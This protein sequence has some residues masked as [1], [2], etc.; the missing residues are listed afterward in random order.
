MANNVIEKMR[1]LET[2]AGRFIISANID[3]AGELRDVLWASYGPGDLLLNVY[4]CSISLCRP[5]VPNGGYRLESVLRGE[6]Y[7]KPRVA[8]WLDS[9]LRAAAGYINQSHHYPL[10]KPLPQWLK[11]LM[12]REE[13]RLGRGARSLRRER[14]SRFRRWTNPC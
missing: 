9:A 7:D 2:E 5:V 10:V 13:R 8:R 11:N 4:N 6:D 1:G 3:D 14:R 12:V